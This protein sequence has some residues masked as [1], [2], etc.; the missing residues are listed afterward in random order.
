VFGAIGAGLGTL[1]LAAWILRIE[2]FRQ[3]MARVMGRL[4]RRPG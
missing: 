4:V 1:A 3:A 2:E